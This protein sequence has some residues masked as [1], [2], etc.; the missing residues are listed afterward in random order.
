MAHGNSSYLCNMTDMTLNQISPMFQGLVS[1]LSW[2]QMTEDNTKPDS[3]TEN[4]LQTIASRMKHSG[5]QMSVMDDPDGIPAGYT[6]LLQFIFH[7]LT[8]SRI[9][10]SAPSHNHGLDNT[11]SA[12]NLNSPQ[13][14]LD[15]LY[16]GGIEVTPSLYERHRKGTA[17][18]YRFRMGK[19][20]P[21]K[22][23]LGNL[24]HASNTCP[25]DL[26]R[27][28]D[29]VDDAAGNSPSGGGID[30]II[31]DWRNDTHLLLSQ[32]LVLFMHVHNKVADAIADSGEKPENIFHLTR[33]FIV[34]S[35][36]YIIINDVMRRIIDGHVHERFFGR[37]QIM[38]DCP[39]ETI[40]HSAEFI[41]A[42]SRIGHGMVRNQYPVN[43]LFLNDKGIIAAGFIDNILTFSSFNRM[44]SSK[45]PALSQK[46]PVPEN[47]IVD[48][49]L[50]FKLDQT[51]PAYAQRISPLLAPRLMSARFDNFAASEAVQKSIPYLDMERCIRF[52][53]PTGQQIAAKL[54][55][56]ILSSS[57]LRAV[58]IPF[59]GD[60]DK[61]QLDLALDSVPNFRDETPLSYYVLH[62]AALAGNNGVHLGPVGSEI[63]A[64]SISDALK[65]S[66]ETHN[67][68]VFDASEFETAQSERAINTMKKFIDL[69]SMDSGKLAGLVRASADGEDKMRS[70]RRKRGQ[71]FA[72]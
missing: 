14:D 54:G 45:N 46:L 70:I 31:S 66:T 44:L 17:A 11:A 12:S 49:K 71:E 59:G 23:S 57:D 34:R 62:E 42:V 48:W 28:R 22:A 2:A 53:L 37:N 67:I 29:T 72:E 15:T 41:F 27:I 39:T 60:E 55:V 30:P 52:R 35:Y 68:G 56:D 1:N 64:R 38:E 18:R 3:A 43:S 65:C 63:I 26:A 61:R 10:N 58:N 33:Q 51:K 21:A 16:G 24:A 5:H 19:L 47:W 8:R 7:D 50:F 9:F 20:G 32:L 69:L 13:L 25:Y 40:S 36:R 4:Y 6:Y